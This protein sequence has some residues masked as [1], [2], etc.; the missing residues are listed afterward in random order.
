MVH[1]LH[2]N[3]EAALSPHLRLALLDMSCFV[4]L[5]Q[6]TLYAGGEIQ[7]LMHRA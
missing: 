2:F 3:C 1:T 6:D 5:L 4:F 7:S